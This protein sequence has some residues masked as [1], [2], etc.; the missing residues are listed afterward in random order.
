[1]RLKLDENMPATLAAMLR[2][3][4]HDVDTSPGEGLIGRPD[5]D[6]WAAAQAA[7]RLLVTQDLD[8]GDIRRFTPGTHHGL[9][10]VRLREPSRVRLADRVIQVFVLP[11]AA[12]WAGCLVVVTDQKIRVRAPRC[13]GAVDDR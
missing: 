10:L 12:T 4:G 6:I 5:L 2:A 11:E 9:L 3:K 1:M 8:F 7:E 13:G